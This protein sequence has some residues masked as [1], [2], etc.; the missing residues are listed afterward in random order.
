MSPS[1]GFNQHFTN[2][3]T[4]P[5]K[6]EEKFE[7]VQM[8]NDAEYPTS[9]ESY[10]WDLMDD[11]SVFSLSPTDSDDKLFVSRMKKPLPLSLTETSVIVKDGEQAK[12]QEAS[13]GQGHKN[14]TLSMGQDSVYTPVSLESLKTRHLAGL[15][16]ENV[17]KTLSSQPEQG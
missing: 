5:L 12:Q 10:M 2:D 17:K 3:S 1:N 13:P 16:Q 11:Q 6:I 8:K 14:E 4:F 15:K 7:N 9:V